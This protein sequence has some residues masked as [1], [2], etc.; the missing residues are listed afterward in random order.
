MSTFP[1]VEV[2]GSAFAMGV[3]HGQQAAPIVRRYLAW[4]DK[5]TGLPRAVLQQN[6]M[7][8]L[9]YLKQLSPLYVDEAMGLAEGAGITLADAILCQA[10][11]EAARRWEGGC[12]AFAITRGGTADG[13]PLAGQN[14]DLEAEYEDVAI[15]LKVRPSDGRPRAAMFT[16][17]GQLGY[18]G[19][20]QHGVANFV[21][22]LYNFR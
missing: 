18:A 8:F 14:Q 4:I 16:F 12:T 5:L 1:V 6:A 10:R 21:N 9:P 20:N 22:A 13:H 7:P 11:A 2:S 15:V 17:A 19:M 3:Q